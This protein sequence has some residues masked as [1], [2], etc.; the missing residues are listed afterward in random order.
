MKAAVIVFPGSNCDRDIKC[1]LLDAGA[2]VEL[3]WHKN[4]DLPYRTDL[5][6][7]PGGFSF[8][9]YLRCGAIAA[10]S[11]I[12]HSIIEFAGRGGHVIGICNGFQ[13]LTE[14]DLLP[15]ALILNSCLK[16][17]CKSVDLRVNT[18]SS[19]FTGKYDK[20]QIISMPIAHHE[21]NYKASPDDIQRMQDNDLI[22]FKYVNTPNGATGDI[23]GILS[24]N[25]RIL[26]MMPHPERAFDP[27]L[28][29]TDGKPIFAGLMDGFIS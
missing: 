20:E 24:A 11:P 16:F 6:A 1:A 4:T 12:C 29:G 7:I 19:I 26:G 27:I 13:I 10:H 5:V 25:R 3:V 28:G 2:K 9:D 17:L 14:T 15:G 8:G 23:A 22:A 21:G 18:N